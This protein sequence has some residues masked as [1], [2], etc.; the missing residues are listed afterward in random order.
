MFSEKTWWK[1]NVSF[2]F[3]F[4]TTTYFSPNGVTAATKI[5]EQHIWTPAQPNNKEDS[6]NNEHNK[7][8]PTS[9]IV[10]NSKVNP[11]CQWRGRPLPLYH[12]STLTYARTRLQARPPP[13]PPSCAPCAGHHCVTVAGGL[14][15]AWRCASPWDRFHT[16]TSLPP[17]LFFFFFFFTISSWYVFLNI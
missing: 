3:I 6:N 4:I 1:F 12:T 8:V 17:L 2:C 11:A 5:K 9:L 14:G 16:R 7:H 13:P 10:F 15:H